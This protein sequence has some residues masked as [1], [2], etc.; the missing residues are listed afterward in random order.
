MARPALLTPDV[1]ETIV[2]F[3]RGGAYFHEATAAAGIG[4]RTGFRWLER[5]RASS[6]TWEEQADDGVTPELDDDP[7]WVYRQFWQAV[8]KARGEARAHAAATLYSAAVGAPAQ[9]DENGA[10]VRDEIVPEWRASL[11]YLERTDPKHWGRT[12]RPTEEKD[13]E[14]PP[15]VDALRIQGRDLVEQVATVRKQRE[16]AETGV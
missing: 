10:I 7:E 4:E 9:V 2:R 8:E 16:E 12:H 5:G 13:P 1:H 6:E 15:D 11:A 14:N 3:I